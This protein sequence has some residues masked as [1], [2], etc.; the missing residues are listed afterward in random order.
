MKKSINVILMIIMLS[1]FF[2]W[3]DPL[4]SFGNVG[5]KV[6]EKTSEQTQGE[7]SVFHSSYYLKRAKT[8]INNDELQLALF[9]LKIAAVLS[10]D[11]MEIVG[12]ISA[13]KRTINNKSKKYFKKGEKFYNQNKLQEARKQFLIALRYNPDHKDALNYLKNKLI[14]KEYINYTFEKNDSL[15]LISNKFYKDPELVF[16]IK[17]FNNLKSD[18]KPEP[19]EILRIPILESDFNQTIDDRRQDMISAKNLLEKNRFQE[20][21][22]ITQ[23]ILANDPSNKDAIKLKNEAFYQI[24]IQ[25]RSQEKYFEAIDT[26]QKITPEYDDVNVAIQETVRHVLLKGE[27]L[28]KEKKYEESMGVAEKILG[29]DPSNTAAKK[30]IS[31]SF[32]Q[33]GKDLFIQ[34]KYDDA[35]KLLDKAEPDDGCAEQ[36][37][38]GVKNAIKQQAEAHYIRGVKYFLNQ[39]LQNAIK[40]WKKTLKLNPKH[41][42]AKKNIQNARSLLEKLK[43]VK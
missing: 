35:L 36:I 23:K 19:G 17:Y 20:V 18:T 38:L 41:D 21:I 6:P 22:V 27:N 39:E 31:K 3:T 26:F 9:F 28:L 2:G 29:Y 13:L 1:L 16:L 4:D 14:P 15:K 40:E 32:C 43:K 37:R 12:K 7:K 5:H 8:Y 10:P 34:K 24:G 11:D 30:L 42:K 33:Q 25:L